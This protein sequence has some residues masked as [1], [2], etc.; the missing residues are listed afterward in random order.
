[1]AQISRSTP[2][3]I[4]ESSNW[5]PPFAHFGPQSRKKSLPQGLNYCREF[6]SSEEEAELL[7]TLDSD[8]AWMRNLCSRAQQ[9]FGLVYYHT[10]HDVPLLQPSGDA[11]CGRPLKELPEWLLPEK[12]THISSLY[13]ED[14]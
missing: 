5:S 1:M 12:V 13:A 7:R 6:I 8:G 2:K 9:F 11:Q 4:M 10:S 14:A 3:T